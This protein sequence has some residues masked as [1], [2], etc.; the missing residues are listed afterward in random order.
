MAT[1]GHFFLPMNLGGIRVALGAWGWG[2]QLK[3]KK[4]KKLRK[5]PY[6]VIP[7]VIVPYVTAAKKTKQ[8]RESW[9]GQ[10][11]LRPCSCLF[12]T[13]FL[14]LIFLIHAILWNRFPYPCLCPQLLPLFATVDLFRMD[15]FDDRALSAREGVKHDEIYIN[16][17]EL[18]HNAIFHVQ[19]EKKTVQTTL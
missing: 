10:E 1:F 18:L 15:D 19:K 8:N 6:V 17:S 12:V 13:G 4:T 7:L 11:S 5:I 16:M 3:T 14:F 9:A 2:N